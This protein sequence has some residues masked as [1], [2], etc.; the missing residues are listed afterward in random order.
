VVVAVVNAPPD[1]PETIDR[2]GGQQPRRREHAVVVEHDPDGAEHL[3]ERPVL[4]QNVD[5]EQTKTVTETA[6]ETILLR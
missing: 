2:D 1:R 4:E 3:A 6:N 5:G